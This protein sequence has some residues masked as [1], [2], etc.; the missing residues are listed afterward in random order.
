[1]ST[2]TLPEIL[3]GATGYGGRFMAVIFN[4]DVTP[5]E[6]VVQAIMRATGCVVDEAYMEAWEAHTFGKAAVHFSSQEAC[7]AV[8]TII[9]HIGVKTEV[10]PEWDE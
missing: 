10:R 4:N 8:A 2:Q 1:M 9:S 5:F 6:D 7:A 3:D